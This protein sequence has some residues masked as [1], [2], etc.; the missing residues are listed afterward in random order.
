MSDLIKSNQALPRV[1]KLKSDQS[2][3]DWREFDRWLQQIY[4]LLSA[5]LSSPNAI[6][7]FTGFQDNQTKLNTDN[8]IGMI[9]TAESS[10]SNND[11]LLAMI[12]SASDKS[13][14]SESNNNYLLGLI[15]NS[16]TSSSQ[17]NDD[18][19]TLYWVGV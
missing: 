5:S 18:F 12:P 14:K 10:I 19:L 13:T 9:S 6:N 17:P 15:P 4:R 11:Y 1:P 7:L 8:A 3:Y 16:I 2:G